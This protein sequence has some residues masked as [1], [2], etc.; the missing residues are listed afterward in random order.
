MF[1]S[2]A[3]M[4]A[5]ISNTE[6]HPYGRRRIGKKAGNCEMFQLIFCASLDMRDQMYK[7]N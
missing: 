5:P 1:R 2:F 6:A 7:L 4:D 3:E